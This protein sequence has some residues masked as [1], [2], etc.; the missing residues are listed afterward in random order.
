MLKVRHSDLHKGFARVNSRAKLEISH[1][2][3][4]CRSG[5]Q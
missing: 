4:V 5:A 1:A 3:T 2:V